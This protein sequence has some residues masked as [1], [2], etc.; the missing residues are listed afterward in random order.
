MCH[1]GKVN[2]NELKFP[3][4]S[5]KKVFTIQSKR[6]KYKHQQIFFLQNSQ[7]FE[8]EVLILLKSWNLFP[9]A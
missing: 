3:L 7:C 5:N 1:L 9:D 6:G 8:N 2:T 4:F